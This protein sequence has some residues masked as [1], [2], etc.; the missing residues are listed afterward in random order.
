MHKNLLYVKTKIYWTWT[1]NFAI[2][3]KPVVKFD[4]RI[5]SV[6]TKQGRNKIEYKFKK[7]DLYQYIQHKKVK[8]VILHAKIAPDQNFSKIWL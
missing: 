5:P 4:S 7:F 1:R 3:T 6:L 2:K 8:T